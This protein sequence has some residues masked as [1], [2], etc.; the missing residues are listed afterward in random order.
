[1]AGNI[2]V[3]YQISLTSPQAPTVAASGD[4]KTCAY[5]KTSVTIPNLPAGGSSRKHGTDS[6]PSMTID[7]PSGSRAKLN[8][9]AIKLS[10]ATDKYP[11]PG[12]NTLYYRFD[13][14]DGTTGSTTQK[15]DQQQQQQTQQG[16]Q[17]QAGAS[18]SAD[19]KLYLENPHI[20][21]GSS[22]INKLVGK[23][24]VVKFWNHTDKPLNMD[25]VTAHEISEHL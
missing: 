10:S 6:E 21:M 17:Q 18:T 13:V 1:M 5:Y 7:I 23:A 24:N 19:D 20:L 25:I 8:I 12:T 15:D 3:N 11:E 9:V 22:I 14:D 4:V 16:Q 2:T